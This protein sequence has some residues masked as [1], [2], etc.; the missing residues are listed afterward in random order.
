MTPARPSARF[1]NKGYISFKG[2]LWK[3]PQAFCGERV[4]IRPLSTDG[5]YGVFFAAHHIAN[6]D[7][8]GGEGVGHLSEQVSV[9]SPD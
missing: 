2:R 7:L 5:Q 9:M 8:T 3:V 1:S 4:A 6:I